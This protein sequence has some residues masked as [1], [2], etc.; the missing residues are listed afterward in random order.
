MLWK[1]RNWCKT[2][3][4][5]GTHSFNSYNTLNTLNWHFS[6]LDKP[7][8]PYIVHQRINH[9]LSSLMCPQLCTLATLIE[10][11]KHKLKFFLVAEVHCLQFIRHFT[12]YFTLSLLLAF[13]NKVCLVGFVS[14]IVYT[15]IL[16]EF[17]ERSCIFVKLSKKRHFLLKINKFCILF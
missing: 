12:L 15:L 16:T 17:C 13:I 5:F 10:M 4:K 8:F 7:G 9:K 6:I 14:L 11:G 3:E 1:V 2:C